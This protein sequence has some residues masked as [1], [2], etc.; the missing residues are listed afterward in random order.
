MKLA[1]LADRVAR[2]GA[3][4]WRVHSVAME[5]ASLAEGRHHYAPVEGEAALR[6]AI[7]AA[8]AKRTSQR[9]SACCCTVFAGAQNAL[10]ATALYLPKRVTKPSCANLTIRPIPQ[11]APEW[12]VSRRP[13]TVGFSPIQTSSWRHVRSVLGLS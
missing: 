11:P 12:C 6:E 8:H 9:L 2:E 10:F 1:G 4:A 13:E 7:V 5:R 3:D